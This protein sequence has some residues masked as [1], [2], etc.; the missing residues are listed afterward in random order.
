[1]LVPDSNRCRPNTEVT[2]TN[3]KHAADKYR[4]TTDDS[5][6]SEVEGHG[7]RGPLLPEDEDTE[8]HGLRKGGG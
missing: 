8:G 6:L 5:A 1:M 7:T 4:P 3:T 2:M